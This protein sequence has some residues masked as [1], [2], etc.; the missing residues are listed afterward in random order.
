MSGRILERQLSGMP[1][2]GDDNAP[3]LLAALKKLVRTPTCQDATY[4]NNVQLAEAVDTANAAIAKAE[5]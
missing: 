4:D 2:W 3:G 1:S 5:S